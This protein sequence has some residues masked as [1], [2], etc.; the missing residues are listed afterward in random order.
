MFVEL[1]K[2]EMLTNQFNGRRSFP[3]S[4]SA[5]H[6][7]HTAMCVDEEKLNMESLATQAIQFSRWYTD[8]CHHEYF[9][10]EAPKKPDWMV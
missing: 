4:V 7:L 1:V 6:M 3:Q 2:I 9:K 8:M 10:M 5:T